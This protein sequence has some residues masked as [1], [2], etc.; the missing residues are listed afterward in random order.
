LIAFT[1]VIA[2]VMD[3]VMTGATMNSL[4]RNGMLISFAIYI[5]VAFIFQEFLGLLGLWLALNVFFIVR[6]IIFWF[7]VKARLGQLFPD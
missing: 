6:G 7:A 4:I 3:G 5:I 1:G 2:F